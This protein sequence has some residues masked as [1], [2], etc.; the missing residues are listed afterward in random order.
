MEVLTPAGTEGHFREAGQQPDREAFDA[1]AARYAIR[2]MRDADWNRDLR[3]R[4]GL[5]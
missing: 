4:F 1:M 2:F 5:T 3:E